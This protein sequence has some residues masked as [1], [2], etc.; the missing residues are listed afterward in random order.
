M[1]IIAF[2]TGLIGAACG[3]LAAL[4]TWNN[5]KLQQISENA[6]RPE[7]AAKIE[8]ALPIF[9]GQASWLALAA[10]I[11]GLLTVMLSAIR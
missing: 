11:F 8:A 4:L 1:K 9:A 10:G 6:T 3:F 2:A 5:D 7:M